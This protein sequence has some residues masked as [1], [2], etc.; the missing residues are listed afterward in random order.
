MRIALPGA[1]GFIGSHPVEHLLAQGEHDVIGFD[2]TAETLAGISGDRFTFHTG[3]VQRDEG[4]VA[5]GAMYSE[6]SDPLPPDISKMGALGW[7]PR[8]NLRST[9]R[10][11]TIFYLDTPGAGVP[12][13]PQRPVSGRAPNLDRAHAPRA[14]PAGGGPHGSSPVEVIVVIP[15][16]NAERFL[17]Q[18]VSS[19]LGQ[20]VSDLQVVI[21]DDGSTDDTPGIA[22]SIRDERVVVIT[23]PNGGPARARNAGL[24]AAKPSPYVAFLDADDAWD[25]TKL[26]EQ[27]AY[28][29]THPDVAA[30]GSFM[31]YISSTGKVLGETGQ[32]IGDDGQQQIARGECYP[33]HTSSMVVRRSAFVAAGGFDE[34]HRFVGS[35]DVD[36]YARIVRQGSMMC[37]PKVLGSYRI[38]PDSLMARNRRR[39]NMEA[40]FVRRR[41]VLEEAGEHLT[42]EHFA[43]SY[44]RTW[45]ERRQDALE[46][47]YRSAALCYGE[48]RILLALAYGALALCMSPAYTV[49]RVYRQKFGGRSARAAPGPDAR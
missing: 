6:D 35:E 25:R 34:G 31:R 43:A 21:V 48:G 45:R 18:A 37:L 1:G 28:M 33:F 26:E 46:E 2:L 29:A 16:F 19:A 13:E 42:W 38:H 44:G 49:R 10:D 30:V 22:R 47:V 24:A 9:L 8:R 14:A 17:P 20:T 5:E 39:I 11:A 41:I 15:A 7:A 23:I 40:R 12:L 36:L 4:R 27:L 3:D 32:V